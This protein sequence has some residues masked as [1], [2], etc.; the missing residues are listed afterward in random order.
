MP[1][2]LAQ[3]LWWVTPG[4]SLDSSWSECK[5][6]GHCTLGDRIQPSETPRPSKL[7]SQAQGSGGWEQL[8]PCPGCVFTELVQ[9]QV[10]L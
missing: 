9:Q 1:P 7:E 4:A 5:R 3:D 10:G 6:L 8:W 2:L